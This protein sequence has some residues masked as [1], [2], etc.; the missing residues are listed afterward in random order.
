MRNFFLI[1][2]IARIYPYFFHVFNRFH[3][4]GGKKMDVG[5]QRDAQFILI[6][7]LTDFTQ[8]PGALSIWRCNA[9]NFAADF[10]KGAGLGY[11][12]LDVQGRGCRHGLNPDGVI[13]PNSYIS[14]FDSPGMPADGGES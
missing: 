4:G 2:V 7:S 5:N 6:Q 3:G 8:G 10:D 13:G 12:C 1:G 11:R 14:D 9:H